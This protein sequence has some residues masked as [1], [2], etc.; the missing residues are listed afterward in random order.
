VRSGHR[1]AVVLAVVALSVGAFAYRSST[2]TTAVPAPPAL[3]AVAWPFQGTGSVATA[4]QKD[5]A[6]TFDAVAAGF[7]AEARA[8]GQ[9]AVHVGQPHALFSAYYKPRYLDV[10][11]AVAPVTGDGSVVGLAGLY[12]RDDRH[13]GID[14]VMP[15]HVGEQQVSGDVRSY[16]GLDEDFVTVV[17]G[18]PRAGGLLVDSGG[19]TQPVD[20]LVG[21]QTQFDSR[22]ITWMYASVP[23]T[24]ALP[25][26]GVMTVTNG[27][28]DLENV[29]YYGRPSGVPTAG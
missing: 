10:V 24:V 18:G 7:A 21:A 15:L 16:V 11:V 28:G 23:V 6:A 17:V 4:Q 12:A 22:G 14:S 26:N 29:L 27:N 9:V 25:K 13:H 3:G 5:A 1:A 20:T 19:T 2:G 8:S